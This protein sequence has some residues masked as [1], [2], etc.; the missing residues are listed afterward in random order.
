MLPP[1]KDRHVNVFILKEDHAID[2]HLADFYMGNL[3]PTEQQ[4]YQRFHFAKDRQLYLC[5]HAMLRLVLAAY[6][7]CSPPSIEFETNQYGKPKLKSKSAISFNLSHAKQAAVLAVAADPG[8][9]L[10]VDIE[11]VQ[12]RGAL[13]DLA[14]H[15]FSADEAAWLLQQSPAKQAELFFTLWTLKEAYIKAIGKGLSID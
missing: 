11:S 15:Y 10:G 7:N 5:S 12:D 14:Q 6:L 13:Q 3:N 8:H 2:R 9:D 4:Q 1:L